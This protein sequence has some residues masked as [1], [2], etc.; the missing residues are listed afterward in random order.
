MATVT[1]NRKFSKK[2][3]K[4]YLLW[5]CWA[6]W[7][8]TIVKWSFGGIVF[9]WSHF[10]IISDNPGRQPRCPPLLQIENSA[11][12]HLKISPLKLLGQWGPNY[13]EMVIWGQLWARWASTGSKEPLV[14]SSPCQRQCQLLPSL[15]VCRL[16]VNFSHFNLLLW[17]LSAKLNQT[18]Q[19]WSKLCPTAAPS[20]QDGCCY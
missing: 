16:S 1:K 19:G 2:S 5:N 9:R 7:A 18:W 3:L 8:Q 12:N 14:F 4:N 20:F 11:K 10:R 6:N 15:G 17:N 13:C